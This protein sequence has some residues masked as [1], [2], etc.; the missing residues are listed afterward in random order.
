MLC[1]NLQQEKLTA[2]DSASGGEVELIFKFAHS[3]AILVF[4]TTGM[5]SFSNKTCLLF[6]KDLVIWEMTK[7]FPAA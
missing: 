1:S 3:F 7:I 2:Q 4:K 6:P 5:Y